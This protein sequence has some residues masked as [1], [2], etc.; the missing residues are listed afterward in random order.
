MRS[1]GKLKTSYLASGAWA[2]TSISTFMP[3]ARPATPMPLKIGWWSGIYL[4]M[5]STKCPT[6]SS[7]TSVVWYSFTA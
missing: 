4:R 6:A 7:V 2:L 1:P 3:K 5:L